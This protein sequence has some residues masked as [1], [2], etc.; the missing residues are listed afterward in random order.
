[1][2]NITITRMMMLTDGAGAGASADDYYDDYEHTDNDYH[3]CAK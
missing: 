3:K 1:M 2:A